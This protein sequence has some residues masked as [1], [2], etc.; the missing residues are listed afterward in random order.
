MVEVARQYSRAA[1]E[2]LKRQRAFAW[3]KYLEAKEQEVES[4]QVILQQVMQSIPRVNGELI[5]PKAL[6]PHITSEFFDMAERL[7]RQFTCPICLELTA[8]D[9][10]HITWCGHVLCNS[11]YCKLKTRDEKPKCPLCRKDI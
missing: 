6:P 8:K 5:R 2:K 9:T 4:T 7:N 1:F 10:I 3:A 11:C